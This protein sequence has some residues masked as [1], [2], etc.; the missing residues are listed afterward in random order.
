MSI[1]SLKE[2]VGHESVD[3]SKADVREPKQHK[4]LFGAIDQLGVIIEVFQL[5]EK[6]V[7]DKTDMQML[8]KV[9]YFISTCFI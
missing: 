8:F 4:R 6:L 7:F 5:R 3:G 2:P 9:G 1:H